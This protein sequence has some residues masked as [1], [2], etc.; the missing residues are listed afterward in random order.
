MHTSVYVKMDAYDDLLLS[1]G[2][3]SQLGIVTYHSKVG[4]TQSS[5]T[6]DTPTS[7]ACSVRISLVESLRLAPCSSTLASVKLDTCGLTRPLLLEQTCHLAEHGFDGLEVGK[8]LVNGA[9][10]GVAKVL[11]CNPTGTT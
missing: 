11:I 1:E 8:S 9:T 3:C 10:D 6:V 7:S 2:V 4:R 5:T